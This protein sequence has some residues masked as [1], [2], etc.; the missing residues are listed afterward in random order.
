MPL[1]PLPPS[2][3][4][5]LFLDYVTGNAATSQEHTVQFRF[6]SLPV[7]NPDVAMFSFYN[8]LTEMGANTFAN[9]WRVTGARVAAQG[10][11]VTLPYTL[12]TELSTFIGLGGA[13]ATRLEPQQWT[14]QGRSLASGRRGSFGL[15]GLTTDTPANF[16]LYAGVTGAPA[17]V[18]A[19]VDILGGTTAPV[20]C[21]D[22]SVLEFY[23]YVNANYNNHW[24]RRARIS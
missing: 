20:Q 1:T 12:S 24:E 5:R 13:L 6:G 18:D 19:S 11:D 8:L 16:R 10:S 17:W 23:R 3:T 21:I 9:G 15:F 4:G 22:G 14:W 2:N 7:A